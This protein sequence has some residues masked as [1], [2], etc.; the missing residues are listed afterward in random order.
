MTTTTLRRA[1]LAGACI[2]AFAT[3]APAIA[4]ET[5][6]PEATRDVIVVQGLR[7]SLTEARDI[8]RNADSLLEVITDESVGKLPDTNIA[9][10]INRLTGIYLL[11]DQGEGRYVSIRGVDPI[12]NNVTFN[13]QTIAVSDTDGRSGRAAPL[14]VLSSNSL[15]AVEVI[16]V[17]LP[18]MDG[19]SVGGTINVRT[20][21]AFDYDELFASLRGEFG[22]NDFGTDND[23]YAFD[24]S[25][26]NTFGEN[27]EF[28]VFL[29]GSYFYRDYLSHLYENTR[30]GN[31]ENQFT[32]LVLP[33]RVR[34][35]SA[36]GYRERTSYNA[37]FEYKPVSDRAMYWARAF[38]SEY[39]DEEARPEFT[40]RNRGDIGALSETEFFY[41]QYAI[42][43]ETRYERQERPVEQF[44]IGGRQQV[45]EK[46]TFE[47]NLNFTT[48][49]EL[50]PYLDYYETD[51]R[52]DESDINDLSAAPIYFALDGDG[53]AFP[54]FVTE[55]SG[56]LGAEDFAFHELSRIRNI[57]SEVKEETF[58][59]DFDA[60]WDGELFDRPT[61][62]KSGVKYI[63]RD[64]S[65][66]DDD[67]RFP[68]IGDDPVTLA[69]NGLGVLFRDLGR[70]VAYDT[71]PGL[72]LP[73]PERG[74]GEA[75]R[76]ANPDLFGFDESGSLSNS[77]E[78]DYDL[79]E[80]ISAAFL[81]GTFELNDE[82]TLIAGARVEHTEVDVTAFAFLDEFEQANAI[83]D[84][85]SR[86]DELPFSDTGITDVSRSNEYT[87]V[88]PAVVYRW[89]V[90]DDWQYRASLTTNIGRPDYPDASPISTFSVSEFYDVV[91][92]EVN[93][94]ATVEIGNPD[95][96]PFYAI[97]FDTSLAYYFPDDSGL[98]SAGV[99]YKHIDNAIYLFR[100]ELQDFEFE[101]VVFDDFREFSFQ[102]ADPGFVAGIELALQKNF[103]ELPSPWDGLGVLANLS[104]IDSEV[105]ATL[106]N[107]EERTVPFFN[108]ADSV[109][110]LQVF[111]E[112]YGFTGRIGLAYQGEA[113][114]DE[115]SGDSSEDV[116]RADRLSVD[117][118]VSYDINEN[119]RIDFTGSNLT[120]EPDQTYT[121][122][123]EFFISENPGYEIYGR[124][125]RV[126]LSWR[127]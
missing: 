127:R 24:G 111:Y 67:N 117:A 12:L 124:E 118:K 35:G 103:V 8:Q 75:F 82:M 15:A 97:N 44:V 89:N 33:E 51:T 92:D 108:Q 27:D 42:E 50:N 28:G 29:S 73:V 3:S 37:N 122:N 102:N 17:T 120:N 84:G 18:D 7:G 79:E 25:F 31:P 63:S 70:G 81:M 34:L 65:V 56:G 36:V 5:Q 113:I 71:I 62:V 30:Y 20:P 125:Y 22:Y 88:L 74:A 106:P 9:E 87:N 72:T 96:D 98:V 121:N 101:G 11:P 95:L 59:A 6:E 40:I 105:D 16:K 10:A 53:F 76:A 13:G 57:T 86:A 38:F 119:F 19:Q 32:D 85:R 114:F 107:G 123:D 39:I 1:L 23:I 112:K 94:S 26:A 46:W 69:D 45:G 91:E 47:G 104:L 14:D 116:Y 93:L 48:A 2:S 115:I 110:N 83:P 21:S 49:E 78:D 52:T 80:R 64:K 55:N 41:T 99:F 66:D 109:A 43:N 90:N 60:E 68:Y 58:T 61:V 4:Q 77:I 100:R 54:N 126:G